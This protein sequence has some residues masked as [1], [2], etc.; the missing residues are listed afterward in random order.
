MYTIL[1]VDDEPALLEISKLF[2]E[3][4]GQFSVDTITSAAA[5]LTLMQSKNYDA[6][7]ADYQMPLMD[8]I[9]FLK[10]VRGSGNSVPFILFT[11]RGRE[12]VVIQA[13]NEGADFYLQKGGEPKSQFT[14]L[15][16]KIQSAVSRKKAEEELKQARGALEDR[17]NQRTADLYATNL[18][19]QK[20]IGIRKQIDAALQESEERFRT[21]IEKAPEAILL[22]DVDLDRY[23]EA[24]AKAEELFGSSRQELL[25]AGPQ[26]FY[27]TDQFDGRPFRETVLEHRNQVLEGGE[28]VFERRIR[29]AH[30][31]DRVVE[32][33]LVR[34]PSS[35]KRLIRSSYIDITERKRVTEALRESEE[36]YRAIVEQDY[37][38]MFENIQD[39][40]YRSDAKGDLILITPSGAALLGYEGTEEMIGKAATDYYADPV[41]RDR[42]L[43][44]LKKE[45]SVSNIE[46]TLKRKDGS[47][48][49]VSTSSHVYY[50]A[51]G[52]YAGVEGIFRD[53][54]RFKEVQRELRQS[55]ELYRVLVEHIRDG[56]FLMQDGLLLFCNQAFAAMIGS[57]PAEIIGMPVPDLIAPEDRDMV[58]E[59]Q[60]SR[61]AGRS[62]K[63]SYEFR[64]LHRDGA[65]RVP[66]IL[67]VGIGTYR[68]RPAV[69]GTV[70]DVTK[71][72]GHENVVWASDGENPDLHK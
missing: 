2:L 39:V 15:A 19:L 53:I 37:R 72:C 24:N 55:E 38:I 62:L 22:F 17:V 51:R 20:E 4:D 57:V 58:M 54:T 11:G 31:E 3:R 21:L 25:A 65:T 13:L 26:N 6:V 40:F 18:Q 46:T 49:I 23:I 9:Q 27:L 33:R 71:E 12:E 29:N 45:G 28:L 59:R 43:D 36:R 42:L 68:N 32:V 35:R 52:K 8:G 16:H 63:E 34:L 64:M 47:L 66:V 50:D 10:Q 61:L 70:R 7:I 41:Q 56:A 69:I 67:S 14:E 48:V 44:A 60:R 30:G 5:A 1:Y